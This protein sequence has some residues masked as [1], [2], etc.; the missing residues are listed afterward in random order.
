[1]LKTVILIAAVVF[2]LAGCAQKP[3]P[4]QPSKEGPAA[5]NPPP[6]EQ[7][8]EQP[9][10]E[11]TPAEP[12]K[13]QPPGETPNPPKNPQPGAAPEANP[14]AGKPPEEE[15]PPEEPEEEPVLGPDIPNE[16][17]PALDK[18]D[19]A[20]ASGWWLDKALES[21]KGVRDSEVQ[22]ELLKAI[23][24]AYT[25][26][27][28]FKEAQAA[29]RAISSKTE[30]MFAFRVMAKRQAEAGQHVEAMMTVAQI[31]EA[32]SVFE[33]LRDVALAEARAGRLD[34]AK[35]TANVI[36]DA[37][38]REALLAEVARVVKAEPQKPKPPEPPKS[39]DSAMRKVSWQTAWGRYA[40]ALETAGKCSQPE[41]K[42]DLFHLI[43]HRQAEAG[44]LED[45]VATMKKLNPKE[46]VK[47]YRAMAIQEI[48]SRLADS[49]KA[50]QEAQKI[51]SELLAAA[52]ELLDGA[53]RDAIL[54][55]IVEAASRSGDAKYA[56]QALS[57]AVAAVK[58]QAASAWKAAAL[59]RL[60]EKQVE[61]GRKK[62]ATATLLAA[63][64]AVP[65]AGDIQNADC[66]LAV[67]D[68]QI[69]AGANDEAAATLSQV[70][71]GAKSA[72]DKNIVA[73]A[74]VM[75]R[76]AELQAKAGRGEEAAKT[77]SS[78]VEAAKKITDILQKLDSL[79]NIAVTEAKM[80]KKDEAAK[81]FQE[82][83]ATAG[84]TGDAG[85]NTSKAMLL[86]AGGQAR[87]G[88]FTEARGTLDSIKENDK[89]TL[90]AKVDVLNTVAL[91]Q[92]GAGDA[93][94]AKQT[95]VA[96]ATLAKAIGEQP[97][98]IRALS[99][100]VEAQG[101]AGMIAE[102]IQTARDIEEL[103][104]RGRVL[105]A[106]V[107]DQIAKGNLK[108]AAAVAYATEAS[109]G[110]RGDA[111]RAL[112][113]ARAKAGMIPEAIAAAKES[114][115]SGSVATTLN[116]LAILLKRAGKAQEAAKS[117]EE[118]VAAAREVADSTMR[119][120]VVRQIATEQID[121][122][123]FSEA[124]RTLKDLDDVSQRVTLMCALA[125]E[126]AKR[127]EANP[128]K[129]LAD[130]LMA[131][132]QADS[133]SARLCEF[134]KVA[135]AQAEVGDRKGLAETLF[136][137]KEAERTVE[138][139]SEDK[140]WVV[141]QLRE[142]VKTEVE[143]GL[144]EEAIRTL[145]WIKDLKEAEDERKAMFES[146]IDAKV[147]DGQFLQATMLARQSSDKR[148][149]IE[150]VC[151]SARSGL[152]A[153]ESS[154]DVRKGFARLLVMARGSLDKSEAVYLLA[155]IGETQLRVGRNAD[156]VSTFSEAV[157]AARNASTSAKNMGYLAFPIAQTEGKTGLAAALVDQLKSLQSG[158][159]II[160]TLFCLGAGRGLAEK[161][162]PDEK[163]EWEYQ[164]AVYP[165]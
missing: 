121:A 158:S 13:E 10:E 133:D 32:A 134:I 110:Q 7:P 119:R 11:K 152:V 22:E 146:I 80:G 132:A 69:K 40:E 164:P 53:T 163:I 112:A 38:R 39:D 113:L 29:A 54:I 51:L 161:E 16:A 33:A 155:Y 62:D 116:A 127:H 149:T 98:R 101:K 26:L 37:N 48:L 120:S 103:W 30:R 145:N 71:D 136:Q 15:N 97:E 105:A 118:A 157:L 42:E 140:M 156:A 126:Q 25:R 55:D 137:L 109:T 24:E 59:A 135:R 56:E 148:H 34:D 82:L 115:S 96:A 27:G 117:L 83:T 41:M 60:A 122:R 123:M 6:A 90:A 73:A 162:R 78:A 128:A 58:E 86:V 159:Q 108:E 74:G 23:A 77:L 104:S 35:D 17:V 93:E 47:T 21:A 36:K 12:P 46:P 102:A 75:A 45:A 18:S 131:A 72:V 100:V 49:G 130:T 129:T 68:G 111:F 88:M 95:F 67:A 28:K 125:R 66:L 19:P 141:Y 85:G 154:E 165:K 87:A 2:L 92:A 99:G 147:K 139:A 50:P 151:D 5:Q 91:G 107:N 89:D 63:R 153:G 143:T 1:M 14:K 144:F 138:E 124:V 70:L 94:G 8:K 65:E 76:V 114:G 20:N 106:I 4:G 43:A 81:I 84:D 150:M 142:L 64:E 160:T 44:L 79:V 9:P 31:E 52:K 3:Q 61:A 57:D